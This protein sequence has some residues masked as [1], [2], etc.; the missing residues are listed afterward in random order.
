MISPSSYWD[1]VSTAST[2]NSDENN[3]Q[4]K[5]NQAEGVDE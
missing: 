5:K 3:Y 1:T 2:T 4:K